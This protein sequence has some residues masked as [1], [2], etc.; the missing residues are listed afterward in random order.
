[1]LH[2]THPSARTV[3]MKRTWLVLLPVAAAAFLVAGHST[4]TTGQAPGTP[5][6][7]KKFPDFDTLVKGAKTYDGLFK[8]YQVED[9]LYAE[10]KPDQLDRPFLCPIAI[11]RGLAEG[12]DTLNFGE[13][14]VLA[15][16]RVGDKVHL[17]RR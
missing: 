11:A 7:P 1:M 12:G 2:L 4:L 3:P 10:L 14:W 15:F 13:Q 9:R 5:G 17:V 6:A 8:L 16:H